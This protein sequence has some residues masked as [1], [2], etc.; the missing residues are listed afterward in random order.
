M[1]DAEGPIVNY[2]GPCELRLPLAGGAELT[3]TENT[4]YPAE[5]EIR[6]RLGLPKPVE[7]NLRLRIPRW[8]ARTMAEVN[9]EELLDVGPGTYLSLKRRWR[10]GDTINLSLDMSPRYWAGELA[11]QG[12]AAIYRGPILLAFDPKYNAMDTDSIPPLDAGQLDSVAVTALARFQPIVL[13]KLRAADGRDVVLC[14]F[15]T[16]GAHGTDYVAWLPVANAAPAPV[17][18]KRPRPDEHVAAGPV[19]FEWTGYGSGT[20]S[21][22]TFALAIAGDPRF[23]D[24]VATLTGL[25]LPRHV[26]QEGLRPG[27]TYYWRVTAVNQNGSTRDLNGPSSFTVDPSLENT[28]ESEA[29]LYQLGERDLMVA[30]P[31]DGGGEPTIGVLESASGTTPALD[32]HGREGGAVAFTGEA[33]GI[34]YL[35][36]YFPERDF[37]F[38]AWACP[39]ALPTDRLYQIFSAWC[40]GM[41]D[42]LRVVIHGTELFA[43]IEARAAYSTPGVPLE[44]GKWIHVAA[45]KDG[46][47]LS[48]YVNGELRGSV[49]VPEWCATGARDFAIGANPNYSGINECFVGRIDDFGFHAQALTADEIATIFRRG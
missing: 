41:D 9:G 10:N 45:V 5:G 43:R 6:L 25:R 34:K 12:R 19:L 21:G 4:E 3:L 28:V 18:L 33:S 13:R 32:R 22:R 24:V 15:A 31:L 27:V 38:Y 40:A 17:W 14:D 37:T 30:S 2:Y 23:K 36:P 7:F 11:R 49:D 44:N 46:P 39:E 42:P 29:A 48:L 20:R 1:L 16:A 35:L 26:L 8:S 47:K